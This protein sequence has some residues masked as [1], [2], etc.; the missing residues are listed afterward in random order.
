[1][2]E[3]QANL[4]GMLAVKA[5]LATRG[6][7]EECAGLQQVERAKGGTPRRLGEIMAEKGYLSGDQVAAVLRGDFTEPGRRFGELC[8]LM[9]FST[10]EQVDEAAAEQERLRGQG[11][12]K[13]IGAI[14]LELEYLSPFRIPAVLS[15]Q[16]F[17]L[18]ECTKCRVNYNVSVRAPAMALRCKRCGR[19]LIMIEGYEDIDSLDVAGDIRDSGIM[20]AVVPLG[21]GMVPADQLPFDDDGGIILEEEVELE[22]ITDEPE[23]VEVEEAEEAEEVVEEAVEEAVEEPEEGPAPPAPAASASYEDGIVEIPTEVPEPAKAAPP[24]AEAAPA[25]PAE[26]LEEISPEEAAAAIGGT[27]EVIAPE[28]LPAEEEAPVFGEFR[29]IQRIGQDSLG[30]LYQAEHVKTGQVVTLKVIDVAYTRDKAFVNR[31]VAEAKTAATIEHPNLKRVI[32]AGR[33]S[34]HL[35]YASEFVAGKSVNQLIRSEGRV[36]LRAAAR[37][38]RAVASGLRY[39]HSR[40]IYHGD[41]RPSN[42]LVTPEGGVKLSDAGVAKNVQRNIERLIQVDGV[43]PFYMAPELATP[44]GV[45]DAR[46]DVYELGATYFHMVAGRPPFQGNTPLQILM[47]MAQEQPPAAHLVEPKV[48]PE[49]S[50]VIKKMMSPEFRDR[51]ETMEAVIKELDK[52]EG[53][54]SSTAIPV[55]ME[56]PEAEA[57]PEGVPGRPVPVKKKA[58]RATAADAKPKVKPKSK[59]E[60]EGGKESRARP[61]P[62]K[63]S[64]ALPLILFL[65]FLAVAAAV[66][67]VLVIKLKEKKTKPKDAADTTTNSASAGAPAET[68]TATPATP[69]TPPAAPPPAAPAETPKVDTSPERPPARPERETGGHGESLFGPG[70]K[71]FDGGGK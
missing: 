55:A 14:L 50:G 24:P 12:P 29:A 11:E 41:I 15:A 69:A 31:F 34:G 48:P 53:V 45:A 70:G 30:V 56:Y 19:D 49:V 32:A 6:Q 9:Q 5:G 39:A 42:I 62:R 2:G 60:V 51:F 64:A 27:T 46:S 35:Y 17:E 25:A 20:A 10:Q 61:A 58:K 18:A 43:T 38:V 68:P 57:L 66:I 7:V 21:A 1:M 16:G 23:P 33:A 40:N 52:I 54:S 4:F 44:R 36:P 47:R 65:A 63:P 67:I 59:A 26:E 28:E 71:A 37:I 22:G 8:V 13:R 3:V